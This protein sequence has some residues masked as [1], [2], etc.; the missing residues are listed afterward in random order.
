MRVEFGSSSDETSAP[1]FPQERMKWEYLKL[2]DPKTGVIPK[3]IHL[4]EMEFAK[5]L[6]RSIYYSNKYS[7]IPLSENWERRGPFNIGGRT[8]ALALDVLNEDIILAGG[9][10]GGLW[11]SVNGGVSWTRT[12]SQ[13][14]L[15]TI[16]C[17]TQDVRQGKEKIWY[18]GTGEYYGNS[19]NILGD[20]I[21]KSVDGGQSWQL[22]PSTSTNRLG[23]WDNAFDY[24][25]N[26]VS[27]PAA[28]SQ[29][30]EV[31]AAVA[32]GAIYRSSDGGTSWKPVLGSLGNQYGSFT[33]IAISS[34]GILYATI[35]Q[36][37]PN[38]NTS[39]VKGMFRSTDG[40]TWTDISP[41]DL[42]V[43]FRRIVI[44]ISASNENLLYFLGETPRSGKWFIGSRGDTTF[45][46]LWKYTYTSGDGSGSGG[47]WEN[48]SNNLPRPS[49]RRGQ[50][51]S[52][53]S[54]NLHVKIKPDNPDIVFIGGTNLYRSVNGFKS[55]DKTT[56]IGGY[57]PNQSARDIYTY[58]NQHA[59]QHALIFLP[60]NPN[61]MFSGS[62]G[63]VHKTFNN[64]ADTVAWKSLNNGYYTTQFYTCAID[65]S[66]RNS[67]EIIGGL[68]D[69]G[70]LF[71]NST[72]T[73]DYWTNPSFGD[74]LSCVIADSGKNYYSS[75]NSTN[76]C[77]VKIWR[78][79]LDK[80]GNREFLTRI[81][82]AGALNMIWN[83]PIL[84]D[85]NDNRR[86]YLGGGRLVW[87]NN[88]LDAI[89]FVSSNDSTFINWD[90]LTNTRIEPGKNPIVKRDGIITA[91]DISTTPANVLYYATHT[92]E[93]FKI[94]DA[95]SGNPTPKN[96]TPA[97]F[98]QAY[99]G[100]IKIDPENAD[101]VF[102]VF[103]NY[104]VVS[105]FASSNGGTTWSSISGNLEENP[106]G[107]GSGPSCRWLEIVK[108]NG[109]KIYYIGT[110]IGL[111]ATALIDGQYTCWQQEGAT[112]IGNSVVDMLDARNSD[113]FVAVAT[114]GAGMFSGFAS[115]FPAPPSKPELIGPVNLS[116]GI[117][118]SST[119]S[120]KPVSGAIFYKL[121]IST[122]PNFG[123]IFI[124]KDGITGTQQS[125]QGL[126]AGPIKYYWRV[127]AKNASGSS[128]FSDVWS[129][130]SIVGPPEMLYPTNKADSIPSKFTFSWKKVDA[131]SGYHLQVSPNL[132][133]TVKI[134]DTSGI[135]TNSFE[136]SGLENNQRYYWKVSSVNT[137]GEGPFA[138]YFNFKTVNVAG[139]EDGAGQF[140]SFELSVYPN[141]SNG[142]I[143]IR[144]EIRKP[145]YCLLSL[146]DE[147]GKAVAI[148]FEGA[149][150][151]GLN[152]VEYD[153]R[154]L[155]SGV[156]LLELKQGTNIITKKT[157]ILR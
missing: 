157:I 10:S 153:S 84:L 29:N 114:H 31:Y 146:K 81:D 144:Y 91:M 87:R 93:I 63:G 11:R 123:N 56:W 50:F 137:D 148:I 71:T 94:T 122:D 150:D 76:P 33:D 24:V 124:E 32:A 62:D 131:A 140:N 5:K 111:F 6:P 72:N 119:F 25:W 90:S 17:L 73:S 108:F 143:K 66:A 52:Q 61:I 21:Y 105:I 30:D 77:G 85:P 129:F 101:N 109:R 75:Q 156:Y 83:C 145:E 47:S 45:H 125:I 43:K 13:Q 20:G 41:P 44:G 135:Q 151:T 97:N 132:G 130:T 104:G 100:C 82:P 48:L 34:E 120:W 12:T 154:N 116:K 58:P 112:S 65:R 19:A 39:K 126:E 26:I 118:S 113:G 15:A 27:N 53:S 95:N 80:S 152:E 67:M 3:G 4:R 139:I 54:Y 149:S 102:V 155:S 9:V 37:A 99:I 70:T 78:F 51:N 35:S 147:S 55:E 110:S 68:Q 79:N 23:T 64:L 74:G 133:F 36:D 96:I 142:N 98:P 28:P 107:T 14:Q 59:D 1:Q 136:I 86:M 38:Q 18:A 106:D 16:S 57:N 40:V 69:N 49:Y 42:P 128:Q 88:N 117:Q 141:P 89:P 92:G 8:R 134:L 7:V 2:R 115:N 127:L 60:S 138:K 22:L 121:Q 46:S 103:T